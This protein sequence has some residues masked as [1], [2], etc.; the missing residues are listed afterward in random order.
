MRK[1]KKIRENENL[2]SISTNFAADTVKK[3]YR[4]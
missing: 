2:E 1:K 3:H 4:K